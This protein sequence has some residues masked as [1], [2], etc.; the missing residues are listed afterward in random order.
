MS[1]NILKYSLYFMSGAILSCNN[2]KTTS[3]NIIADTDTVKVRGSQ[4]IFESSTPLQGHTKYLPNQ[5]LMKHCAAYKYAL[6]AN[7]SN[8]VK[9]F[10]IY[11]WDYKIYL[12][13]S[14]VVKFCD[15]ILELSKN[16]EIEIGNEKE[17]LLELRK[18]ARIG[19]HFN[20]SPLPPGLLENSHFL[21][22]DDHNNIPQ[23]LL[24]R[25]WKVPS[26]KKV[27]ITGR[28]YFLIS[29]CP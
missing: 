20:D 11:C 28:D 24:V 17:R 23:K 25:Y 13:S 22:V 1:K 21:I 26:S 2:P 8:L 5:P 27:C 29:V 4:F 12:D 6:Y 7:D 14:D 15:S 18:N 10:F 19:R 9:G 16:E 3:D